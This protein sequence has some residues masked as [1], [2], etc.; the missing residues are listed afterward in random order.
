VLAII[1]GSFLFLGVHAVLPNWKKA[2][3]V[4]TFLATLFLVGVLGTLK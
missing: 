3:V 2:G 1:A 4:T